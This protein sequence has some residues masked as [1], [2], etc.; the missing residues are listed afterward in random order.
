ME[1]L[2]LP[3]P[4]G[5]LW[6]AKR[7]VIHSLPAE[8]FGQPI[9]PHIG[10]GTTL[11]ARWKHRLSADIDI[12]LPGRN[13]LIDLLQDDERNVVRRLGGE[14][15]AVTDRRA[16][17][18]FTRGKI[19]L[20]IL[21]PDPAQGHAEALVDGEKE[22][23]LTSAQILRGKLERLE[24]LLVRDVF[25]VVTAARADPGALA[26]AA[27]MISEGR[28]GAIQAAWEEA[29]A[30]LARDFAEEIE[31]VPERYRPDPA[32]LGTEAARALADHRY[33]RIEVEIEGARLTVRRAIAV[34]PLSPESYEAD[35]AAGA[36][37]R[38]GIA[39][40]L[41]SNGPIS[42]P[43]L[44]AAIRAAMAGKL[45]LTVYDSAD[46]ESARQIREAAERRRV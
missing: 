11:A 26:T 18:A 19:D 42:A 10:G 16:K 3:G 14:P 4:A 34:G 1:V 9:R 46:A 5:E 33:R 38:S 40:H 31:G 39:A 44:L 36:L 20:C 7:D 43:Q 37:I 35:D 15:E 23:V 30:T 6:A 17:I 21:K 12:L 29:A 28:A 2:T 13:T 25:D 45:S 27:S 24:R 32:L 41:N 22:V 8:V